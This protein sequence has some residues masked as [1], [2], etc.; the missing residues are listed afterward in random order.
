VLLRRSVTALLCA[1]TLLVSACSEG[2]EPS[3]DEPPATSAPTPAEPE[4]MLGDDAAQPAQ[5][6]PAPRD[7]QCRLL[8]SDDVAAP[9]DDTEPVRCRE[10]H[11]AQTFH[12]GRIPSGV[13]GDRSLPDTEGIAGYVTPRCNRRFARWIGGDADTRI[14][15]RLH[16]VWFLPS[17]EDLGL[18]ARWFRCDAVAYG[19]G[20]EPTRLSADVSGA[21]DATDALDTFGLCSEGSPERRDSV[22]LMCDRR[23]HDWR[24]FS[25]LRPEPGRRDSYPSRKARRQARQACSEAAREELDFPLEWRYGWQPPSRRAWRTG[26]RHGLCWVPV[27]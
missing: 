15:S 2:D 5:P 6:A 23:R 20:D 16:S 1:A 9:T 22:L 7:G 8:R 19:N 26:V 27:R 13:V 12:V 24:A 25:V 10:P 3:G 11:T 4:P 21:L 17:D 14:L 18:G